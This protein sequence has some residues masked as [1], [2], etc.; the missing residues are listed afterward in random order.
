VAGPQREPAAPRRAR[1]ERSPASA[2]R[3]R[4][5]RR[6]CRR[7]A[8][9]FCY[10]TGAMPPGFRSSTRGAPRK[11]KPLGVLERKTY[12]P[13]QSVN[14]STGAGSLQFADHFAAQRACW[15]MT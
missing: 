8:L 7:E 9:R 13:N 10:R 12:P 3:F 6:R 14:R 4:R 15:C 5:A 1:G 2:R 11:S